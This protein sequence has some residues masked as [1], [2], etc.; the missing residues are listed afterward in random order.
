MGSPRP[1]TKCVVGKC[2]RPSIVAQVPVLGAHCLLLTPQYYPA[3]TGRR[4]VFLHAQ[5]LLQPSRSKTCFL[6]L[7]HSLCA[8][9]CVFPTQEAVSSQF[10]SDTNWVAS[11]LTHFWH[12]LLELA[13]PYPPLPVDC[14]H[15]SRH[16]CATWPHMGAV[17]TPSSGQVMC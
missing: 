7:L 9:M 16:F 1:V 2:G 5:S 3:V 13:S 6:P 14:R 4:T 15:W 10:S 17:M 12:C 11:A 8:Q